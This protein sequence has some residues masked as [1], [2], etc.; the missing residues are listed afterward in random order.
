M[1]NTQNNSVSNMS[2]A[3]QMMFSTTKIETMYPNGNKSVGTGFMFNFGFIHQGM[4]QLAPMIVTNRHVVEGGETTQMS[5]LRKDSES[6]MPFLNQRITCIINEATRGW[7]FHPN[8]EVDIAIAPLAPFMP[9]M[10]KAGIDPYYRAIDSKGL[11]L[12]N[13]TFFRSDALTQIVFIGYPSGLWDALHFLPIMRMGTTATPPW[14]DFGGKP[15]FL[16]D[17][18]VFPGSSGSPVFQYSVGTYYNR[19]KDT[20]MAHQRLIS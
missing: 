7:F 13:D 18:S 12:S 1:E 5:F 11:V 19:E 14:I 6:G 15:Q 20:V 16:I 3:E 2:L 9:D 4:R 17:A 10:R 8:P